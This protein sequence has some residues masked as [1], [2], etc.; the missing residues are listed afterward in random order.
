M[1]LPANL[2]IP[3]QKFLAVN[4]FALTESNDNGMW[5]YYLWANSEMQFSLPYDKGY[6]ECDII[7]LTK[8]FESMA[9][10]RLLRFLKN[11]KIFYSE[12]LIKANL[13]YTLSVNDY[14]ELFYK[15]Y[16]LIQNFLKDYSQEKYDNYNK[17]EFS[18][19]GLPTK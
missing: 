9:I 7:S 19:E 13:M 10:I 3:N 14:V 18:Y 11:D 1:L 2:S 17:F 6:Y 12:E 8:P 4:S 5:K 16:I 15:N